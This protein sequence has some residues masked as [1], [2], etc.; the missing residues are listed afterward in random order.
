MSESLKAH[1]ERVAT[2][3]Q[4]IESLLAMEAKLYD[5][6][7][8]MCA[9]AEQHTS[10]SLAEKEELAKKTRDFEAQLEKSRARLLPSLP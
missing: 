7:H 5:L 2:L 10:G 1:R 3:K 6:H 9:L 8:R 4:G